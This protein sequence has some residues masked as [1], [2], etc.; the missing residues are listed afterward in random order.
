MMKQVVCK[1]VS[2]LFFILGMMTLGLIADVFCADIT[3]SN[4]DALVV[5]KGI[6]NYS[7]TVQ[8]NVTN[9][10]PTADITVTVIALDFNGY[11]LKD[12]VLNG[13]IEAGKTKMLKAFVQMPKKTFEE[14]TNWEWKKNK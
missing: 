2:Y 6:E 5:E 4:I 1:P 11:Q 13:K 10:G 3:V 8:A 12:V 7:I 14:I 9:P